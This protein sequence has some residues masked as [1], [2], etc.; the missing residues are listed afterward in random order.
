VI[1]FSRRSPPLGFDPFGAS[2]GLSVIFGALATV[3]PTLA[4]VT[5]TFG[6]LA[7][8]AWS[9]GGRRSGRAGRRFVRSVRWWSAAAVGAAGM[10]YLVPPPAFKEFRS[11]GLGLALALLW[12]DAGRAPRPRFAE[13][14]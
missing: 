10:L 8:A 5:G 1:A 7:L 12:V 14:R 3:V 2:V 4:V 9:V 13:G 11:L 6:A